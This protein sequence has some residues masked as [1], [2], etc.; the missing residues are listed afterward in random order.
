M[1]NDPE[2]PPKAKTPAAYVAEFIGTYM[3]VLTVGLNV[4][5]KSAG[6]AYSIAAILMIMIYALG[7]VSGANFNPAVTIA[8]V[9]K[10]GQLQAK[11][12]GIYVVSQ[13]F[14][15][16]LA[17]FTYMWMAGGTFTLESN[18]GYGVG[19]AIA[20]E[21][22]YT[23]VLCY[24][25]LNVACSKSAPNDY[26]GLAIGFSIVA[27]G[28]AIG[29]IS[30]GSLNPA[31]SL[32]VEAAAAA[33]SGKFDAG[34]F[35]LYLLVPCIGGALAGGVDKFTRGHEATE[36]ADPS[37]AQKLVCEF[38]GTFFLVLT[39]GLNVL[40][41]AP[42]S[43]PMSIAAILMIM[44]YALGPVSGA[45]FNPAVSTAILVASRPNTESFDAKAYG[46]YLGAQFAGGIVAGIVYYFMM[47][48]A[49]F[50]SPSVSHGMVAAAMAEIVFTFVLSYVVL[51]V[52]TQ[53]NKDD[54]TKTDGNNYFGLAIGFSIVAAGYA[55]G[56]ISGG[57]LNP[58]VTMG[59]DL[60]GAIVG[61]WETA[62]FFLYLISGFFGGALAGAVYR[63]TSA[64]QFNA[65]AGSKAEKEALKPQP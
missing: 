20:A 1:G 36:G 43:P 27:A 64:D 25:V 62:N 3:L 7:H 5:G 24:V 42:A 58:A 23:F 6:G 48:N 29:P 34:M 18:I 33:N 44:I 50:L 52:A 41:K 26:Y 2:Q 11:D 37:L 57:S 51:N 40:Q 55:I 49:P 63:F 10:G 14:G 32:G 54:P 45:H 60:S 4:V 16:L 47:G 30:G 38:I 53:P 35:F 13:L 12:A 19:S 59:V 17:G 65:A 21:I 8:L 31:V 46:G 15:G 39:V 56:G 28:L 61:K 9:V 22:L